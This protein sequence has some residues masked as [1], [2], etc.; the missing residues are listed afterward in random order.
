MLNNSSL[1]LNKTICLFQ[2]SLA[3]ACAPLGMAPPS[4]FE[5]KFTFHVPDSQL[6]RPIVRPDIIKTI[7]HL[8]GFHARILM[9]ACNLRTVHHPVSKNNN[10][11]RDYISDN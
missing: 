9:L 11:Y 4:N 3:L 10:S 1:G 5:N 8:D 6:P 2:L 7:F